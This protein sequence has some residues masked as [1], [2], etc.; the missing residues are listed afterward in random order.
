M[1]TEIKSEDVDMTTELKLVSKKDLLT[2]VSKKG[3]Y[4]SLPQ[5]HS[6]APIDIA[7][8]G[9]NGQAALEQQ[10]HNFK[11]LLLFPG[12]N[13]RGFQVPD[14]ELNS[15]IVLKVRD[16]LNMPRHYGFCRALYDEHNAASW[17]DPNLEWHLVD[18][19]LDAITDLCYF[20]CRGDPRAIA[21]SAGCH[22]LMAVLARMAN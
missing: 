19:V 5:S 17:E 11:I 20:G 18:T 22:K 6:E 13:G 10:L 14:D 15:F 3:E 4:Y 12:L 9:F 2:A 8:L 7:V 21:I 16:P 1:T